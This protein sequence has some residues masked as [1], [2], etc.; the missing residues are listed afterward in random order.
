MQKMLPDLKGTKGHKSGSGKSR[1]RY[2][3][4]KAKCDPPGQKIAVPV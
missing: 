1:R 2:Y 4:M 3:K